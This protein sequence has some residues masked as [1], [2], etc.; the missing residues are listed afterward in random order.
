MWFVIGCELG[1]NSPEAGDGGGKNSEF[2]F[3][4]IDHR[5]SSVLVGQNTRCWRDA[6]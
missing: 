2:G 1:R 4:Q 5:E 6:G 3:R